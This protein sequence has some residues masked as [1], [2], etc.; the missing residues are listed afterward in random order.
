MYMAS[1][2]GGARAHC[3]SLLDP[4][5]LI[6][7]ILVCIHQSLQ[8]QLYVLYVFELLLQIFIEQLSMCWV[9]CFLQINT[10]RGLVQYCIIISSLHCIYLAGFNFLFI[11][12]QH[13]S[14]DILVA[15][16]W[17]IPLF[18]STAAKELPLWWRGEGLWRWWSQRANAH[19]TVK[20]VIKAGFPCYAAC[21]NHTIFTWWLFMFIEGSDIK[22]WWTSTS[23]PPFWHAIL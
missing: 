9:L 17:M 6:S 4:P 10:S 13:V 23:T 21:I 2:K 22:L 18:L 12:V 14:H 11:L 5:M 16:S 3:A 15:S 1:Q 8:P 20:R 19:I 7:L